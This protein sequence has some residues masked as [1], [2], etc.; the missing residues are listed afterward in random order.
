CRGPHLRLPTK[1]PGTGVALPTAPFVNALLGRSTL[2]SRLPVPCLR[3]RPRHA[4][5]AARRR[6][7]PRNLVHTRPQAEDLLRETAFVLQAA[8]RVKSAIL[9]EQGGAATSNDH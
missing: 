8:A 2:M 3:K 1:P 5:T 9:R 7:C 6:A 4:Q